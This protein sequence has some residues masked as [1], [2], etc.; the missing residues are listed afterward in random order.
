MGLP[1]IS[2]IGLFGGVSAE[3]VSVAYVG[4]ISSCAF[5]VALAVLVSTL[6]RRVRYAVLV[7]YVLIF[8]WLFLPSFVALFGSWMYGLAYQWIQPVNE[9]LQQSSPFG[10]W[11]KVA[12][13]GTSGFRMRGTSGFWFSSLLYEFLWMV[14]LQIAGRGR[15]CSSARSGNCGP[16]F[17]ARRRFP[18]AARGSAV[19]RARRALAS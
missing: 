10:V 5:T 18:P 7:S 3:F 16:H 19:Q 11:I 15:S 4:T 1:V 2:L 8:L 14:G 17:A 12:L 13:R 6:A 9:W